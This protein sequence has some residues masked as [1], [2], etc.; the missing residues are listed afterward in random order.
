MLITNF[1][2]ALFITLG[3]QFSEAAIYGNTDDRVAPTISQIS[4]LNSKGIYGFSMI[5][6]KKIKS[7]DR[8]N[9]VI[10]SETLGNRWNLCDDE[11]FYN[12]PA[13]A[14]CSGFAVSSNKI[15]TAGHCLNDLVSCSGNQDFW[16]LN[17]AHPTLYDVDN[18]ELV[19]LRTNVF[20]C[21]KILFSGKALGLD[22]VLLQLDRSIPNFI[23]PNLSIVSNEFENSIKSGDLEMLGSSWGL[24]LTLTTQGSIYSTTD[25][26][27]MTDLDAYK[28][29]SGSVVYKNSSLQLVG[30]LLAGG[31]D[32]GINMPQNGKPA[33]NSSRYREV[34]E[35]N[36]EK[37]LRMSIILPLIKNFLNE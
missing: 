15:L 28:V 19:V 17:F 5:N 29:N 18:Q 4:E 32:A 12:E 9:L 37:L 3:L 22:F 31:W 27:I 7:I 14:D 1:K 2:I 6:S 35:Q 20:K 8:S 30:I 13:P 33:C 24:P 36:S 11:R 21:K 16:L 34:S 25:T 10:H 26:L 23:A